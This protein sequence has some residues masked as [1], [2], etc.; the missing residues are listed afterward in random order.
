M[1][2]LFPPHHAPSADRTVPSSPIVAYPV[3]T[4]ASSYSFDIVSEIDLQEVDNAV[5]QARKELGQRYDFKG[6]V[7]EL[8]LDQ[9]EK[10]LTLT[11]GDD[12]HLKAAVDILQNKLI[13]R[14]IPLKALRYGTPETAAHGA[15]RQKISLL[16]GISKEDAKKIVALIKD[17]KIRVQAQIMDDQVRVTGKDKDDLQAA[18][19]A[20]RG[21]DLPFAVQFTNYR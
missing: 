8:E 17:T 6:I 16:V 4:V 21:A 13:K 12:Y 2:G 15:V 5:N 10:T 18:I 7:T 14:S 3:P 11:T 19:A 20:V 1:K 9:K